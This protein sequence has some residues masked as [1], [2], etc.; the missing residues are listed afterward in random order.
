LLKWVAMQLLL[1]HNYLHNYIYINKYNNQDV[2][3][4]CSQNVIIITDKYIQLKLY[5]ESKNR[6]DIKEIIESAGTPNSE[7][8]KKDFN[9]ITL[10]VELNTDKTIK[11]FVYMMFIFQEF[12]SFICKNKISFCDV[13]LKSDTEEY[14]CF[15]LLKRIIKNKDIHSFEG[16]LIDCF[17]AYKQLKKTKGLKLKILLNIFIE[18][19]DNLNKKKPVHLRPINITICEA[20][21]GI[22]G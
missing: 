1:K 2:N 21:L 19:N 17:G 8:L 6:V 7:I 3:I 10:T 13:I 15:L 20:T 5:Y 4:P 14:H 18:M 12:L 16:T 11:Q 9:N 22:T